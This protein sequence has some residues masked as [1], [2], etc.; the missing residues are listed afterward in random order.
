MKCFL[1]F[2]SFLVSISAFSQTPFKS[3]ITIDATQKGDEISPL[4]YGQFIE[5]LGRAITGGIYD[6]HSKLSDS[7]GFRIDVLEKVKELHT[8]ILRYPGGTFTKMYH[9]QDGVANQQRITVK[10]ISYT[11]K[12]LHGVNS[13]INENTV[14]KMEIKKNVDPTNFKIVLSPASFT[15]IILN[16]LQ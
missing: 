4:Q 7:N 5:H 8:P 13:A 12:S 16:D 11:G 9:W 1:F 14:M 6:E 10:Q 3:E 15:V 2:L